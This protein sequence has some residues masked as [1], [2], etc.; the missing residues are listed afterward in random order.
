MEFEFDSYT[1]KVEGPMLST[2]LG[3]VTHVN[4]LPAQV[5]NQ[6][7][8]VPDIRLEGVDWSSEIIQE[9]CFVRSDL[10]QS[11]VANC[12]NR[13]QRAHGSVQVEQ[14]G[15]C[16]LILTESNPALSHHKR[17]STILK[18]QT[19]RPRSAVFPTLRVI[20]RRPL[21]LL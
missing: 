18:P 8:R 14:E 9:P 15:N 5:S 20:R 10:E 7:D 19:P 17:C 4:P 1:G 3:G 21:Q 16:K 13:G 11:Q 2:V 6:G 12:H